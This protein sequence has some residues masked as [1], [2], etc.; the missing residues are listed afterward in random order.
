MTNAQLGR[1]F[2]LFN[3]AAPGQHNGVGLGLALCRRIVE[4]H[5]GAIWA[6]S[7]VGRGTT[8]SFSLPVLPAAGGGPVWT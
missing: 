2:T 1:L 8:V 5:G 6:E 7:V 4:R 3:K